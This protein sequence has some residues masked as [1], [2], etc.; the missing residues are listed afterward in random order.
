MTDFPPFRLDRENRCVWTY[1]SDGT[2]RR[3]ALPPRAYDMLQY[4]VDHAGRLITHDE[5]LDA[6]WQNVHVQPDALK[7]H[8]LTIRRA[9]GD[10]PACPAFI[11]THRSR[12]YRFI[13][14]LLTRSSR[15]P[16]QTVPN[17]Q[18]RFVGRRPQLNQLKDL[19][20]A[21]QIGASHI[22]FVTGESGIG[23]TAL[24]EQF[25]DLIGNDATVL[26]S[27][28]CCIEGYGG[29]E[30]YYPVLDALTRLTRSEAGPT[31]THILMS[32]APSWASRISASIPQQYR[33]KLQH[34][35]I[36]TAK[37]AML[38]EI[39]EFF[40]ALSVQRS[41]VLIFENLHWADYSTV[42][43]LSALARRCSP[44]RLMV[45]GTYQPEEIEVTRHPLGQLSSNL[46]LQRLCHNIALEPLTETAIAEYLARGTPSDHRHGE[47]PG[48]A[49]RM[50]EHSGGNPLFLIAILDH[51]AE[52]GIATSTPDGWTLRLS[53]SELPLEV[54]RILNQ[55]IERRVQRLTAVQQR[56]L[57]GASVSGL[58]FNATTAASAAG[59]SAEEFEDICETLCRQ[60]SFIR[61]ELASTSDGDLSVRAY[62]FRHAIY[63]QTFYDRQGRLRTA[64]SWRSHQSSQAETLGT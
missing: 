33:A 43:M 15:S 64:Q 7:T 51:L 60:E 54:P 40:E 62:A 24:I 8:I 13:A 9:L 21:V 14:P 16:R 41:L 27:L 30:P 44:A 52:R 29:I 28:G 32:V 1:H 26:K 31:V 23:K 19:F 57:E 42:D 34:P 18:D 50:H 47:T 20:D 36:G 45:I 11:E 35:V 3:L 4:L 48:F 17:S 12:G 10:D 38:R 5:F 6:L 55:V 63:R 53:P 61:R 59:M 22:V 25:L 37:D 49:Q 2:N 39:C 58:V 46:R 56:V